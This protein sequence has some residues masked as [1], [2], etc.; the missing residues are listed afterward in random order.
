LRF[1]EPLKVHVS[2]IIR[3]HECTCRAVEWA[4]KP[5]RYENLRRR[6]KRYSNEIGC[7]CARVLCYEEM[8]VEGHATATCRA[9]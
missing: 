4:E 1:V 5:K 7:H 9:R 6:S 2:Q 3:S 8:I